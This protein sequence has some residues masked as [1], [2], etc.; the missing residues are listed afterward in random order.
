MTTDQLRE[1]A[2]ER[3]WIESVGIEVYESIKGNIETWGYLTIRKSLNAPDWTPD[4][5][6]EKLMPYNP[7]LGVMGIIPKS[8]ECI[9]TNHGWTRIEPDGS[10]LPSD[11]EVL[12]LVF[13]I[14]A[15]TNI[16]TSKYTSDF[17]KYYF[18]HNAITHF[19]PVEPIHPPIY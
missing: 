11:K 5:Y 19:K 18:E 3:A 15:D 1:K 4:W 2:I 13:N 12:Y 7:G 10:N 6:N 16:D 17:V 9:H 14:S 8:L